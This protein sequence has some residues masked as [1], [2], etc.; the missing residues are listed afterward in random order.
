MKAVELAWV[1]AQPPSM[2]RWAGKQMHSRAVR[3]LQSPT[4]QRHR[5][6][7]STFEPL[8]NY[9]RKLLNL[10]QTQNKY[11]LKIVM[12]GGKLTS[13]VVDLAH[14]PGSHVGC[15]GSVHSEQAG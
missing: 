10:S 7:R 13:C 14:Q 12:L 3:V 6:V 2:L 4:S 1:R 9:C 11:T 8:V 15:V 5:T